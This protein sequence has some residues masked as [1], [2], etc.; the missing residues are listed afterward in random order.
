M[1]WATKNGDTWPGFAKVQNFGT[2]PTTNSRLNY[3]EQSNRYIR[4]GKSWAVCGGIDA[5]VTNAKSESGGGF[6]GLVHIGGYKKTHNQITIMDPLNY[7]G[8]A[9]DGFTTYGLLRRYVHITSWYYI[10][11]NRF[12][13]TNITYR[14]P[15]QRDGGGDFFDHEVFGANGCDMNAVAPIGSFREGCFYSASG[16]DA[17]PAGRRLQDTDG[18]DT[19]TWWVD[20]S[21]RL[22]LD[23]YYNNGDEEDDVYAA[24]A[25]QVSFSPRL[26]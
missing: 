5:S 4:D 9:P 14:M 25:Y 8:I 21:G 1:V 19:F 6:W 17:L 26:Y 11:Y 22:V 3:L 15:N 7:G 10:G 23:H 13:L 24:I 18:D 12:S 16:S 2:K 20:K